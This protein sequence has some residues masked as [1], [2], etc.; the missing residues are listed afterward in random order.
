MK[1]RLVDGSLAL[2]KESDGD[3]LYLYSHSPGRPGPLRENGGRRGWWW[4]VLRVLFAVI[5]SYA[6]EVH[7]LER[8]ISHNVDKT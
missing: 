8:L 1:K 6:E 5:L 2:D 3:A 4:I 7:G